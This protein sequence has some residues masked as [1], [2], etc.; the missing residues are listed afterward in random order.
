MLGNYKS[1]S[2]NIIFNRSSV[3]NYFPESGKKKDKEMANREGKDQKIIELMWEVQH[4]MIG[5][6]KRQKWMGE[7]YQR[8]NSRF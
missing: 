6:P 3:E 5:F 4:P 8:K 7:I 1:K 2:K